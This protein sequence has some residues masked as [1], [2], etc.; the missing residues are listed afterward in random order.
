M[1]AEIV[2]QVRKDTSNRN[3]T[4]EVPQPQEK[5]K[6]PRSSNA[7]A[8]FKPKT[9]S[10]A[11]TRTAPTPAPS[12]VAESGDQWVGLPCPVCKVGHIIKG[13]TAYGCSRWKEG[14]TYRRNFGD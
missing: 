6:T 13:K 5:K 7:P 14:C 2:D 4:V 9:A 10:K 3:V 11:K 8:G 1:V 12:A